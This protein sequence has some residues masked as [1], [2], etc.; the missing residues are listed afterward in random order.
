MARRKG[1]SA[2]AFMASFSSAGRL[3]PEQL[4]EQAVI[5]ARLTALGLPVLTAAKS[6]EYRDAIDARRLAAIAR[7]AAPKACCNCKTQAARWDS[8]YCSDACRREFLTIPE[9]KESN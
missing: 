9:T 3:A 6:L 2:G 1:I 7:I 8:I 4:Q 5:A